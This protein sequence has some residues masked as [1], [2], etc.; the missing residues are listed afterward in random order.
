MPEAIP[1]DF[2]GNARE[3]FEV[4]RAFL[5]RALSGA[6][7]FVSLIWHPWSLRAFD[8]EQEMLSLTF[9][10]VRKRGLRPCTYAD[11]LES[12]AR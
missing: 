2:V 5:D 4:N 7:S 3:E 12:V 1:A 10:Y 9:A 11:L 6:G 8:P